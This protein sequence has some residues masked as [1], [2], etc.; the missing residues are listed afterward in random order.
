MTVTGQAPSGRLSLDCR[1]P[2]VS[3]N[4]HSANNAHEGVHTLPFFIKIPRSAHVP[5]SLGFPAA[6]DDGMPS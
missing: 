3:P 4:G 6:E 5:R 1:G 2:R